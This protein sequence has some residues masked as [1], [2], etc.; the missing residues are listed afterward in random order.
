MSEKEGRERIRK[1]RGGVGRGAFCSWEW[2]G[3][4]GQQRL[5]P[6]LLN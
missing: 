3:W 6:G 2:A 5:S 1:G 4:P